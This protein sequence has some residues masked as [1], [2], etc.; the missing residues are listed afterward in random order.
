MGVNVYDTGDYP[1]QG[2]REAL[3]T[4]TVVQSTWTNQGAE[5]KTMGAGAIEVVFRM[6][7]NSV[8]NVTVLKWRAMFK[9]TA[10]GILHQ[11]QKYAGDTETITVREHKFDPTANSH[12]DLTQGATEVQAGF[13]INPLSYSYCQLQ[14]FST[15]DGAA[16]QPT[17]EALEIRRMK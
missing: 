11:E 6:K 16:G 2:N 3:T 9:L 1:Y 14:I 12:V 7:P 10:G 5:F 4:A 13:L 17:V 15:S 8:D